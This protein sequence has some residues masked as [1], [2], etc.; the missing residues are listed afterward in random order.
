MPAPPGRYN[1]LIIN[2]A[3]RKWSGE[4]VQRGKLVCVSG[5]YGSVTV[6]PGRRT[7]EKAAELALAQ[8]V[9]AWRAKRAG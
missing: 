4:W 8:L 1:H 9:D 5:A 6:D 2:H 3:G 7:P